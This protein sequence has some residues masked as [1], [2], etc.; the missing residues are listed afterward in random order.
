MVRTN[1]LRMAV[2]TLAALASFGTPAIADASPTF[3]VESEGFST[4]V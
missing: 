4:V 3:T 2:A 1:T